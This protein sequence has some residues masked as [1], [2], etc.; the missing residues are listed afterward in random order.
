MELLTNAEIRAAEDRA[1]EESAGEIENG[2]PGIDL[3]EA[4][5]IVNLLR[6][7]D[8]GA[9]EAAVVAAGERTNG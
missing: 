8:A 3:E 5:R 1:A 6:G 2:D 7:E 4:Y 9:D